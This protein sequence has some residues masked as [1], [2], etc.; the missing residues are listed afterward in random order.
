MSRPTVKF[1]DVA[2]NEELIREMND[3]EYA[4]HLTLVKKVEDDLAKLNEAQAAKSAAE[5][6]LAALGLDADDLKALGL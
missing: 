2:T 1:F 5:A 3:E 4:V 6:K